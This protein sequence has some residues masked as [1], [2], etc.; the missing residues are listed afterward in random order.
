MY[1][2]FSDI[3]AIM[4]FSETR[5][6]LKVGRNKMLELLHS[7]ELAAF[8]IGNRWRVNREDLIDYIKGQ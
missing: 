6:V 5:A 8:Q 4:T 3:P 2:N 7:G 1:R